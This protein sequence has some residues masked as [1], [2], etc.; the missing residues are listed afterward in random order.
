MFKNTEQ[1]VTNAKFNPK[2]GTYW[3][4]SG[5]IVMTLTI[6][7]I[8]FAILHVLI[9]SIFVKRYIASL[10]CTLMERKLIVKRGILN[11]VEKTIPL[12]KITDVGMVQGPI[13]RIFGIHG[14]SF[15]TAGSAS[16]GALVTM[17]GIVDAPGFREKV[18]KQRDRVVGDGSKREGDESVLSVLT[19]IRDSL[20][21][22]EGRANS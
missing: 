13:M 14:L 20:K 15:E 22:L 19:E 17:Q 2:T 12:D 9:G 1:V 7:G 5:A 18:L 8:P 3:L 4:F 21:R 11:R 10:E 6:V 16:P